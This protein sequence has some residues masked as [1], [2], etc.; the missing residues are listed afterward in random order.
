ML[1]WKYEVLAGLSI[2]LLMPSTAAVSGEFGTPG[3]AYMKYTITGAD[4]SNDTDG[5]HKWLG[6][7]K[8]G[9]VTF[10]GTMTVTRA[11]GMKS[12]VSLSVYLG[13]KKHKWP[14]KGEDGNVMGRTVTDSF[15]LSYTPK[16]GE[17]YVLGGSEFYVCGGVCWSPDVL[18]QVNPLG[19]KTFGP[20]EP[21][22]PSKPGKPDWDTIKRKLNEGKNLNTCEFLYYLRKLEQANPGRS[23]KHI[24]ARIHTQIYPDDYDISIA[25]F[26]LYKE[27]NWADFSDIKIFEDEITHKNPRRI[28]PR[29]IVDKDGKR[30]DVG[31]TYAG[32]RASINRNRLTSWLGTTL[33]T[34]A[35]DIYQ[36]VWD[37]K[38]LIAG[39]KQFFTGNF[40][41]GLNTMRH[42]PD[43]WPEYQARGNSGAWWLR[44]HYR[45]FPNDKLSDAF[46]S[47]LS[48]LQ[49][50]TC[51]DVTL[52]KDPNFMPPDPGTAGGTPQI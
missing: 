26:D 42:A 6:Y 19:A 4:F 1:M 12:G 41:K 10:S 21:E 23:W 46:E 32:L 30:I 48:S 29:F 2:L 33:S 27:H 49:Q 40:G 5:N 39:A 22:D 47:W 52:P 36:V 15:S 16:E 34:D 14:G 9:P 8:G 43:Y 44:S 25:G 11:K 50:P 51:T 38:G 13:D 28:I 3:D 35:G 20:P 45:N 24:L 37:D 18:V 17:P 31:H 7:S